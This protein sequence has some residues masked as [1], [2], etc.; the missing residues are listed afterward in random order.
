MSQ[1]ESKLAPPRQKYISDEKALA[2]A[3][4]EHERMVAQK[5]KLNWTVSYYTT[6][7][8]ESEELLA[9]KLA[10]LVEVENGY[11]AASSKRFSPT[12]SVAASVEPHS[13]PEPESDGMSQDGALAKDAPGAVVGRQLRNLSRRCGLMLPMAREG[14]ARH[15]LPPQNLPVDRCRPLWW[16][17]LSV[18][19]LCMMV[20]RLF[21]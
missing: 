6:K 5:N 9:A 21:G 8:Q 17:C 19:S 20:W 1:V 7:L 18:A 14:A 11:R 12:Q 15:L 16:S 10:E 13:D 4:A 2:L 3:K